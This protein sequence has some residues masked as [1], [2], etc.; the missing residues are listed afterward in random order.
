MKTALG[1]VILICITSSPLVAGAND[2][3]LAAFQ[4]QVAQARQLLSQGKVVRARSVLSGLQ[5]QLGEAVG[6][7][8]AST[9]VLVPEKVVVP[10]SHP[11]VVKPVRVVRRVKRTNPPGPVG[12]RGAGPRWRR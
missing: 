12:G 10:A 11:V 3:Q 8:S 7:A 2:A 5:A 6:G 9:T 4:S 1:M